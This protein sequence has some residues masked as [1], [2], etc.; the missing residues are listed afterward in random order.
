MTITVSVPDE[1]AQQ[2]A[3]QG[4]SVEA[5]VEELAARAVRG[6]AAPAEDDRRRAVEGLL[7]FRRRHCLT[8]GRDRALGVRAWLHEDHKR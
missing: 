7:A 8:L 6:E 4:L 5:F 3:A 1:L 2:A